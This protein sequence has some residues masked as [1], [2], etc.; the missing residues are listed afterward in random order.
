MLL[1]ELCEE[2]VMFKQF[3][4]IVRTKLKCCNN[5][6]FWICEQSHKDDVQ[7]A[8]FKSIYKDLFSSNAP[9]QVYLREIMVEAFKICLE[10]SAEPVKLL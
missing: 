4:L 8:D 6:K 5:L 9:Y 1:A 2:T 10:S 7:L 3:Y